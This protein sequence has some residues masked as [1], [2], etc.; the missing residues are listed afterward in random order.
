MFL[1]THKD[2]ET[3]TTSFFQTERQAAKL[4]ESK[5]SRNFRH[6]TKLLKEIKGTMYIFINESDQVDVDKAE[7]PMYTIVS[8]AIIVS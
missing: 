7:T 5:I 3:T 1:N 4:E 6:L 2:C 8:R